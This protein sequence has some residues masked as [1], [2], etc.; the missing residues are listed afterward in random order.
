MFMTV[1]GEARPWPGR[2]SPALLD[3][4]STARF[5]ATHRATR[6]RERGVGVRR[7]RCLRRR[8]VESAGFAD[9]VNPSMEPSLRFGSRPSLF[10][11]LRRHHGHASHPASPGRAP[12]AP[13]TISGPQSCSPPPALSCEPWLIAPEQLPV[14]LPPP[15]LARRI[16]APPSRFGHRRNHTF[17]PANWQIGPAIK[18]CGT[19]LPNCSPSRSPPSAWTAPTRPQGRDDSPS[20]AILDSTIDLALASYYTCSM[21]APH[22]F[23]CGAERAAKKDDEAV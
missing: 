9:T 5:A 11:A 8:R 18:R 3:R 14:R 16:H 1:A 10:P 19:N 4:V 23:W 20:R 22:S 2:S 6:R 15:A 12:L 17:P 7:A 13:I 21:K